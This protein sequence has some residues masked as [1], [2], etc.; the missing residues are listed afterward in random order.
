MIRLMASRFPRSGAQLNGTFEADAEI[1]TIGGQTWALTIDDFSPEE[2][3]FYC[4]SPAAL[5]ANLAVAT[6]SDLLAAGAAPRF[7]MHAVTVPRPADPQFVGGL[8]DGIAGI[9]AQAGCFAVGGDIGMAETW[10][11]CGFAMGQIAGRPVTRI[12]PKTE[13]TLWTTGRLGDANLAAF[14][15]ALTPVF[16]LRLKEA[17]LVARHGGCCI[18]TSSGLLNSLWDLHQVNPGMVIRLHADRVPLAAGLSEFAGSA[19]LPAEAGLVGG[20][21]E[22]ELLFTTAREL[23]D[24]VRQELLSLG[25]AEIGDAVPAAAGG[26]QVFRNGRQL[27][28]MTAPPPCP[29]AAASLDAYVGQV[30]V[31][32]V[33]LFR[34]S[35]G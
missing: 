5:G 30:V 31:T 16:E 17:A 6:L 1:V 12:M 8:A 15:K 11:Y 35:G 3:R 14:R 32:A 13:Q 2:D 25:A 9:L 24:A 26:I 21:G 19:G 28:A 29:R 10:R 33:S 23:P 4:S 20:A 7:Y 27:S 18:D 22:Y 34:E